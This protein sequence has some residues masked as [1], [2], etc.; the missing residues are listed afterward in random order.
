MSKRYLGRLCALT[1]VAGLVAAGCGGSSDSG[2]TG[3]SGSAGGGSSA[4]K[5]RIAI[6]PKV[7]GIPYYAAVEKG[8]KE[9]DAELADVEVIWTG[10]KTDQADQQVQVIQNLIN[11]KVDAIA[12]AA[13]DPAAI[14]P[15]LRQ[16][17]SRGIKVMSWDGDADVRDIF[18]Q[19]VD[20]SAFGAQLADQMVKQV[21]ETGE[22][23]VVTS[24][25]TAP[26]QK[27]WLAGIKKQIADKHPGLKIVTTV[28]SQEDQQ[29][30]FKVTKDIL[31]S[32][33]NVKGIFA[34]TTV[35]L[36]G[37]AQ[38]VKSLGKVGDVAVVGNSTPNA[39]REYF[40]DDTLKSAVLWNPLDH[41][42]LAVYTARQ[43]AQ[44]GV[45]QGQTFKAGRLGSY[46]PEAD[47][48]SLRI[49]L[50]PPLVFTKSNIDDF[51]F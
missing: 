39:I 20:P 11:S 6:V 34:I 47:D 38:A 21:G 44:A 16:A 1:M 8:V 42:Y 18:V 43:L 45:K 51:D 41:G 7:I 46:T 19:L 5:L 24:T 50:S 4:K 23:A 27:A 15:V 35:A 31:K 33:P 29:L 37:A 26:N 2:S 30:A 28:Q 40:K 13:N 48:K 14:A 49:T 10:A 32:H 17:E 3:G 36:P 9:A 22:V 12:V 25:F